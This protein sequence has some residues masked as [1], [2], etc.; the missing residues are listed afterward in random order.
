MKNIVIAVVVLLSFTT[1]FAQQGKTV[2]QHLFDMFP[3]EM[4]EYI[5]Q[6]SKKVP[7]TKKL[8]KEQYRFFN[9]DTSF[10]GSLRLGDT[11]LIYDNQPWLSL[12]TRYMIEPVTSVN[13]NAAVK[14]TRMARKRRPINPQTQQVLLQVGTQAAQQ[15]FWQISQRQRW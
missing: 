15:L 2:G 6:N 8:Q 5:R 14:K 11:V 10:I 3:K 9:Q 4:P 12:V 7:V 1:T 13:A